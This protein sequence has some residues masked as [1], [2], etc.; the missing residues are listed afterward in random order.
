LDDS[1]A[2][3]L[4]FFRVKY[5]SSTSKAITIRNLLNHSS[6]LPDPKLRL[7]K[8]IHYEG[9]PH[10]KQT[11]LVEKVFP[12]YSELEFEPGGK[13]KYSNFGYMV[14]GAAI[15]QVTNQSYEDYVRENILEPLE[16]Y[17]TDFIYTKEM[18]PYEA[19][20]TQ[21]I[22]NIITLFVPI[23]KGSVVR[24]TSEKNLWFKRFYNDQT[25]PTG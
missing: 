3:Y 5:P 10:V 23:V 2:K 12:D 20:G 21:P 14:L 11:A 25:P 24:E 19:T 18:E 17:H 8:W 7:L 4:P 1:V 22:Y 13:I 15:E 6:G 9:E 16:M